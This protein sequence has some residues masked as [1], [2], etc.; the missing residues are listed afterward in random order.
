MS[1]SIVNSLVLAL[2][3]GTGVAVANDAREQQDP[4]QD[5]VVKASLA[6]EVL[7]GPRHISGYRWGQAAEAQPAPAA[8]S[9]GQAVGIVAADEAHSKAVLPAKSR[10]SA[11][12][13]MYFWGYMYH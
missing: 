12:Q 11:K 10:A 9:F 7:Y 3:I 4:L 6:K 13:A 5:A 8:Y 1:K 2:S